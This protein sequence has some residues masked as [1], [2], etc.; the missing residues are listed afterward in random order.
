MGQKNDISELR[1]ILFAAARGLMDK[2]SPMEIERAKAI[3]D[4]GDVIIS[5]ARVEVAYAQT[6]KGKS[7]FIEGSITPE[8]LPDGTKDVTPAAPEEKPAIE[9]RTYKMGGKE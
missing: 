3:C 2:D 1:S 8:A 5:A 4:V 9:G 7:A 6:V